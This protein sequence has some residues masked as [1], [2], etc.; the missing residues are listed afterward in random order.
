MTQMKNV[1][2]ALLLWALC[3]LPALAACQWPEWDH[4]R[5]HYISEEGRV[6]D[7]ADGRRI[8]T[9]EGQSYGL[10]FALVNDDRETFARLL[11]WTERQLARGDLTGFLPSWLWGERE[12]GSRTTCSRRG[13]CG[14]TTATRPSAPCC[15][16][17]SPGRKSRPCLASAPCCCPG[18]KAMRGR[19]AGP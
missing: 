14:T 9:S 15:C 18:R 5:E 6:I 7:P 4:F 16:A 8:T 2:G 11:D 17:A 12:D 1:C 3:S 13:A 19:D 10:F